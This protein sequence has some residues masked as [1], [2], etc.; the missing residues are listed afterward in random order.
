MLADLDHFKQVNDR[1]GHPAG[2]A[3]LVET[4]R[5]LRNTVD[6]EDMIARIGGE[7]FMI[8]LP[9]TT[10]AA[11]MAAADR[12]CQSI[13]AT[14]F[15][16]PG[17]AAPVQVTTSIGVVVAPFPALSSSYYSRQLGDQM[18]TSLICEA[19]RALY[20]AKGA[21]RNQVTLTCPAA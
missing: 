14:P 8:V 13:N 18:T 12:I 11:A 3:V 1:F 10:Q 20:Q 6:P 9:D 16:V 7:E 17:A 5:R 15:L 4:A 19:D 2:D 21:G